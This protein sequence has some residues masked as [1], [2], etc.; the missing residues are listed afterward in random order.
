MKKIMLALAV[1]I[2]ASAVTARAEQVPFNITDTTS[3]T[4]YGSGFLDISF[5]GNS[6]TVSNLQFNIT[7]WCTYSQQNPPV[8]TSDLHMLDKGIHVIGLRGNCA[9]GDSVNFE[10]VFLVD[11]PSGFPFEM[12]SGYIVGRR[13]GGGP[14]TVGRSR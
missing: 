9:S 12:A 13:G 11:E 6:I 3:N 2:L 7:G 5:D 1:V 8:S 14:F 4:P 10:A